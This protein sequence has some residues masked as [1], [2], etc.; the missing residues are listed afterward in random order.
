MVGE[1]FCCVCYYICLVFLEKLV[2]IGILY[3][4]GSP[5]RGL[6]LILTAIYISLSDYLPYNGYVVVAAFFFPKSFSLNFF[7]SKKNVIARV[8]KKRILFIIEICA[9]KRRFVKRI[10][11]R[12]FLRRKISHEKFGCYSIFSYLC[13]RDAK[14]SIRTT[15]LRRNCKVDTHELRKFIR[16]TIFRDAPYSKLHLFHDRGTLAVKDFVYTHNWGGP[17]EDSG[18][19]AMRRPMSADDSVWFHPFPLTLQFT[20]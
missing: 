6:I 18:G 17:T 10:E 5:T 12:A 7:S 19:V 3:F 13:K 20:K 1:L 11:K 9:K 4:Y 15:A 2:R 8:K 14:A 16:S